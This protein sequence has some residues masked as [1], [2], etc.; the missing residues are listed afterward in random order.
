MKTEIG[1]K[2]K[3]LRKSKGLSQEQVADALC[4]S[5]SAYSRIEKGETNSW[6]HLIDP[7]CNL[8][9]ITFEQLLKVEANEFHFTRKPQFKDPFFE[10]LRREH[11]GLFD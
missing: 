1:K 5:Q 3:K 9:D 11:P 7:I 2:L 4:I 8:Y 6:A 10:K